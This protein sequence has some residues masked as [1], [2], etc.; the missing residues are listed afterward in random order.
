[1]AGAAG[2]MTVPSRISMKKAPATSSAKPRFRPPRSPASDGSADEAADVA[3]DEAADEGFDEAAD[4]GFDDAADETLTVRT[5]FGRG[6]GVDMQ[7]SSP[8]SV[9]LVGQRGDDAPRSKASVAA[10]PRLMIE[11]SVATP[12][13][14]TP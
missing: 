11:V 7:S 1:M 2:A 8:G 5:S 10:A 6:G 4:E 3:S 13:T 9:D 14:C 12:I